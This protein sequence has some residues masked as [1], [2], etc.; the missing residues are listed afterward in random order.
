MLA[1]HGARLARDATGVERGPKHLRVSLR[2]P[3]EHASSRGTEVGTVEVQSDTSRE[4]ARVGLGDARVGAG[5]A[6][7]GTLETGLQ[8]FE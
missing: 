8:T 1:L 4:P 5:D 2:L 3:A 6:D 7:L